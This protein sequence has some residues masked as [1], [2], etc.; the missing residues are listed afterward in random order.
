MTRYAHLNGFC[1]ERR[2]GWDC[3]GLPVE[4]EIDKQLGV[5]SRKDIQEVGD[6]SS[7]LIFHLS[8]ENWDW[9]IQRKVQVGIQKIEMTIRTWNANW[10]IFSNSVLDCQIHRD[11]VRQ[12]MAHCCG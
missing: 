12:R 8:S 11:A 6:S 3:H 10:H 9:S 7:I 4:F 5:T 1:V 2:F